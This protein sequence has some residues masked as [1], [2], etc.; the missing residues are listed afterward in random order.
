MLQLTYVLPPTPGG[1]PPEPQGRGRK[2]TCTEHTLHST[3]ED[4]DT[5]LLVLPQLGQSFQQL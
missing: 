3:S 2:P 4:Q 1:S 5:H